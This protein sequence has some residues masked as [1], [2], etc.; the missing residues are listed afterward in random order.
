MSR[1]RQRCQGSLIDSHY[2]LKRSNR[3]VSKTIKGYI[4]RNAIKNI[5]PTLHLTFQN[6]Q[7]QN[8]HNHAIYKRAQLQSLSLIDNLL[9]TIP[10]EILTSK[11]ELFDLTGN[12]ITNLTAGDVDKM[13]SQ[14]RGLHTLVLKRNKL[15]TADLTDIEIFKD[16]CNSKRNFHP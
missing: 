5:A 9:K 1:G 8:L 10:T 4:P 12:F 6:C 2:D 7:I 14:A 16:G 13:R 3:T 15:I 11:I